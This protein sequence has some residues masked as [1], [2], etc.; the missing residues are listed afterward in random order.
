MSN[1]N[2][3]GV[4]WID[5]RWRNNIINPSLHNSQLTIKIEFNLA[6]EVVDESNFEFN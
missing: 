5:A 4:G 6:C 2:K 3:T 1:N